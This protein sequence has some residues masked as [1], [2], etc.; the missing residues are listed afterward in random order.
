LGS[1]V[2]STVSKY[3]VCDQLRNLYIYKSMGAN[4]MHLSILREW[5]DVVMKPHSM[6]FA[7]SQQ[8]SEVSGDWKKKKAML[9]PFLRRVEGCPTELPTC[10]PHLCAGDDHG[11]DSLGSCAKACGREGSDTGEPV[12]L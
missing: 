6:I 7:K 8:L 3:Q 9:Y 1:S 4:E 12:W 10:Q 11:T 5:T 2:L